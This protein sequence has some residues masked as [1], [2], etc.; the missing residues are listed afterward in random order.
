MLQTKF[1]RK[2]LKNVII[3]S[4]AS[5]VTHRSA[6]RIMTHMVRSAGFC[7]LNPDTHEIETYGESVSLRSEA[8]PEE[9]YKRINEA[10]QNGDMYLCMVKR[11]TGTEIFRDLWMLTN[12]PETSEDWK[13]ICAHSN[14]DHTLHYIEPL[15]D[16]NRDRI[17]G[18]VFPSD[19]DEYKNNV[20][21]TLSQY[22]S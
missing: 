10:I 2:G 6:S 1:V 12:I 21:E 13:M 3:F 14:A 4:E 18:I 16:E 17:M 15:T 20:T 11:N 7:N 8:M 19:Q 5:S 9:D 22:S